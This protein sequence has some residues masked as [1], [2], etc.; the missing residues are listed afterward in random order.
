MRRPPH[1]CPSEPRGGVGQ[2]WP[3]VESAVRVGVLASHGERLCDSRGALKGLQAGPEAVRLFDPL[4]PESAD[5]ATVG[6]ARPVCRRVLARG[7]LC[8]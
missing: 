1:T 5:P 8:V 7:F 3:R 6:S 2:Q 4:G